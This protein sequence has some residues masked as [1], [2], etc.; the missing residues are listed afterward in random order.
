ML[1][2]AFKVFVKNTPPPKTVNI[3]CRQVM[4]NAIQVMFNAI[5]GVFAIF[6]V[7]TANILSSRQPFIVMNVYDAVLSFIHTHVSYTIHY[8]CIVV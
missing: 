1:N 2:F 6:G 8:L 3:Y 5:Q 7:F 4:F